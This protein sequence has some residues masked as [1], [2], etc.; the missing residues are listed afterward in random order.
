MNDFFGIIIVM[1]SFVNLFGMIH[2]SV[3]IEFAYNINSDF[4]DLISIALTMII[5]LITI[6][7]IPICQSFNMIYLGLI[8]PVSILVGNILVIRLA[9]NKG[10]KRDVR[11]P[12]QIKL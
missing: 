11:L 1:L 9:K 5:F 6:V 10:Y 4:S 7:L 8:L 3:E 12:L 2:A